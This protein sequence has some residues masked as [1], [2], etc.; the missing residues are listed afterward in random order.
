[1]KLTSFSFF[2]LFLITACTP[3]YSES[4]KL[5]LETLKRNNDNMFGQ[6]QEYFEILKEMAEDPS[7]S[8]S[9]FKK[10]NELFAKAKTINSICLPI[11][12]KIELL[13]SDNI[14]YI[15]LSL[16]KE[17]NVFKANLISE[18]HKN[19]RNIADDQLDIDRIDTCLNFQK[20][21]SLIENHTKKEKLFILLA[22]QNKVLTA[23]SIA[24]FI[25]R[26]RI[27]CVG[28]WS[29]T[30]VAPFVIGPNVALSGDKIQLKIAVA[31]YDRFKKPNI[32]LFTK[33]KVEKIVDG[34][35][36]V[37]YDIPNCKSLQLAGEIVLR[38]KNGTPFVR[39]WKHEVKVIS[40]N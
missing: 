39:N 23:R 15:P 40:K 4:D 11:N 37:N 5:V 13:K 20:Q 28:N 7:T 9:Y 25:I 30:D 12:S 1:M 10:T 27:G 35:A 36:Y 29:F 33:G 3:Q 26:M 18:L 17:L 8:E 34:F 6:G 24:L 2:I 32:K 31:A 16:L 38:R 22:L 14:N 19:N 21:A